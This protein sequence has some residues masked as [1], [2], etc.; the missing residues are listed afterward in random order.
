ME[1]IGEIPQIARTPTWD[2]S[3]SR[4]ALTGRATIEDTATSI[5]WDTRR[6]MGLI[7][8]QYPLL[9]LP[10][11]LSRRME[12]STTECNDEDRLDKT[13]EAEV[14]H[15][16]GPT[17]EAPQ[18]PTIGPAHLSRTPNHLAEPISYGTILH[19]YS[20]RSK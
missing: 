2:Y 3:S 10:T 16:A 4:E 8:N 5:A 19:V 1:I 6:T 20:F 7:N 12:C 15:L 13:E 14:T 17:Y 18:L 11:P 9:T